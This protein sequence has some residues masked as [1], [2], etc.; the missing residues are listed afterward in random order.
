MESIHVERL[1]MSGDLNVLDYISQ[2]TAKAHIC[3]S[4]SCV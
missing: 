4:R 2:S 3:F 1:G